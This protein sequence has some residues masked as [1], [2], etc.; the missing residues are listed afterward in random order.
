MAGTD[1]KQGSVFLLEDG[2]CG[3]DGG[4]DP[5]IWGQ[6]GDI[7]E[8]DRVVTDAADLGAE[9]VKITGYSRKLRLARLSLAVKMG[10]RDLRPVDP[11]LPV[12]S[13]KRP[14]RINEEDVHSRFVQ[15]IARQQDY[16]TVPWH[17][18][19]LIPM[20]GGKLKSPEDSINRQRL[21]NDQII[22]RNLF[23]N[24]LQAGVYS[25]VI[26]S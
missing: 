3:V 12:S 8:A 4:F 6:V 17:S 10:K 20:P 21:A 23:C 14:D 15:G 2:N 11:P 5:V 13:E 24:R 18:R 7:V 25:W 1:G 16:L 19:S 9:Q 22:V 26:K